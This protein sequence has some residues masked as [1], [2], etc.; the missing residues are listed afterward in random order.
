MKRATIICM[1][2][3]AG[4]ECK[5]CAQYATILPDKIFHNPKWTW[6]NKEFK[7]VMKVE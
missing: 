4:D 6:K 3:K 2:D 5:T 7:K 1:C